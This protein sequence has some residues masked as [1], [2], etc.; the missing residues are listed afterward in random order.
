MP[1]MKL[2]CV[3]PFHG[4]ERGDEVTDENEVSQLLTSEHEHHFV[5]VSVPD[6]Q[7]TEPPPA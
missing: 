6:E 1:T 3:Q 2:V 5:R 4:Y 7:P